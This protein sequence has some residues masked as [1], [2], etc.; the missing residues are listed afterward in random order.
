MSRRLTLSRWRRRMVVGGFLVMLL[1]I[2]TTILSAAWIAMAANGAPAPDVTVS[3][4]VGSFGVLAIVVGGLMAR[5]GF[6]GP[7]PA[8]LKADAAPSRAGPE[9]AGHDSGARL[10]GRSDPEPG[11]P[12]MEDRHA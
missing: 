11:Q 1:G 2:P 5:Y 9:S 3:S 7:F 12:S 4:L 10:P 6:A 8:R